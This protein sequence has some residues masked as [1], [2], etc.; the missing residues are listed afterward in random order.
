[1]RGG[2]CVVSLPVQGSSIM[3]SIAERASEADKAE[4]RNLRCQMDTV[5]RETPELSLREIL[6]RVGV[7]MLRYKGLCKLA[8]DMD[9]IERARQAAAAAAAEEEEE[10]AEDSGSLEGVSEAAPSTASAAAVA[11][12]DDEETARRALDIAVPIDHGVVAVTDATDAP[13]DAFAREEKPGTQEQDVGADE[14]S[15]SAEVP[16]AGADRDAESSESSTAAAV[17]EPTGDSS[18]NREPPEETRKDACEASCA[19]SDSKSGLRETPTTVDARTAGGTEV[20][21]EGSR[22]E[23]AVVSRVGSVGND[24]VTVAVEDSPC[25]TE[26]TEDMAKPHMD[27]AL[28][29][30]KIFATL[31][32]VKDGTGRV[33]KRFLTPFAQ[34]ALILAF[35]DGRPSWD[36]FCARV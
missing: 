6:E 8:A 25:V 3:A 7:S 16:A 12:G 14:A 24:T 35:Q 21:S 22:I 34:V 30:D 32:R 33:Q 15:T 13:R 11:S 2:V 1:M 17:Q 23:G 19:A 4:A 10:E 36:L 26:P 28:A 18:P 29:A 9:R 20:A 31:N 27:A 5:R